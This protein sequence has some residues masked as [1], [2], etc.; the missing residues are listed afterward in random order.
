MERLLRYVAEALL[1]QP[2]RIRIETED[3]GDER[4]YKLYLAPE[5]LGRLIGRHGKTAEALRTL[6]A[7]VGRREH[8]RVS[9][10]IRELD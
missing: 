9:L 1:E 6:L 3:Q 7:A 8:S 2:E 10:V 5:D 4:T